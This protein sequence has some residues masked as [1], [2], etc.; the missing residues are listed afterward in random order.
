MTNLFEESTVGWARCP[1]CGTLFFT[2]IRIERGV[3]FV[4]NPSTCSDC[5]KEK[6]NGK[7]SKVSRKRIDNERC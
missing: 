6:S 7:V 2:E 1:S 4:Y 3:G 5:R